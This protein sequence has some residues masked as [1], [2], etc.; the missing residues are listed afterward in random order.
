MTLD[1][2]LG[3]YARDKRILNYYGASLLMTLDTTIGTY[4]MDKGILKYY[5][6]PTLLTLERIVRALHCGVGNSKV[7]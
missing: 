3:T 1:T 7:A 2:T 5:G 4:T 6:A